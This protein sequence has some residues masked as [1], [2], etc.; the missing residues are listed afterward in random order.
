MIIYNFNL[1]QHNESKVIYDEKRKNAVVSDTGDWFI[2]NGITMKVND[3]SS[4]EL[5][6]QE[7]W[8]RYFDTIAI[9]ERTNKNLQ[10]Q[11]IPVRYWDNILELTSK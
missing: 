6:F 11:F 9:H 8:K 10:R 4:D 3:L 7:M 5:L 2:V 1:R